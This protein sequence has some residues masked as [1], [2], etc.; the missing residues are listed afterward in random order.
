[1][2]AWIWRHL[3]GTA[4]AKAA[5]MATLAVAVAALL[6]FVIFPWITPHL[7]LDQVMP[8]G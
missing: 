2:Y 1:M 8:H 5:S 3:P 4:P 7:P 6:W